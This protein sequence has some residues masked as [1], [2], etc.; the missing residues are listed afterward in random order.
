MVDA[1]KEDNE[2]GKGQEEGYGQEVVLA[3][4]KNRE[5]LVQEEG[6]QR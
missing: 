6:W 5:T 3:R 2:A 4:P 1:C